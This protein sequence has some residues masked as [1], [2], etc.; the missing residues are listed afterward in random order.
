[1]VELGVRC[2]RLRNRHFRVEMPVIRGPKSTKTFKSNELFFTLSFNNYHGALTL[3]TGMYDLKNEF[4]RKKEISFE[5]RLKEQNAK[6]DGRRKE[7][8]LG[9]PSLVH[10][11]KDD[12]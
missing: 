4:A 6:T 8:S 12:E 11:Q 3:L 5:E 10:E 9:L 1:M 7:N 2:R